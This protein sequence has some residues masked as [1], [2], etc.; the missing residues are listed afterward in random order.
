[1]KETMFPFYQWSKVSLMQNEA[2][3][4]N[5][6]KLWYGALEGGAPKKR[7]EYNGRNDANSKMDRHATLA[8]DIWARRHTGG[9]VDYHLYF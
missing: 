8:G 3:V 5:A 1:L 2:S 9:D 6:F 4:L 7:G